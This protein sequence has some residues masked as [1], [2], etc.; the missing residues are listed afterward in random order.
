MASFQRHCKSWRKKSDQKINFRACW[1]GNY[2]WINSLW[3]PKIRNN[4]PSQA[5]DVEINFLF[6]K[7]KRLK[8]KAT[9]RLPKYNSCWCEKYIESIL[10]FLW[11]F[12]VLKIQRDDVL[13]QFCWCE[14]LF[15]FSIKKRKLKGGFDFERR[16]APGCTQCFL[17]SRNMS[18][19]VF[20]KKVKLMFLCQSFVQI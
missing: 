12:Q 4:A 17:C 9:M 14:N 11:K 19:A 1:C 8:M 13:S 18:R 2:F 6:Y 3:Q 16:C 20:C 5:C 15:H 10:Y 7:E